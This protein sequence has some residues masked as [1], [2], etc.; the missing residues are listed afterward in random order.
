[1]MIVNEGP[2]LAQSGHWA[3]GLVACRSSPISPVIFRSSGV[4]AAICLGITERGGLVPRKAAE[5]DP[6]RQD[7]AVGRMALQGLLQHR[8]AL[9]ALAAGMQRGRIDI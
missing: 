9:L 6:R 4:M 5:R 8:H 3:W 2:L 7:F 1:M